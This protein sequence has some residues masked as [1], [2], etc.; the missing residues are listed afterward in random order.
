MHFFLVWTLVF[1]NLLTANLLQ[2]CGCLKELQI[3]LLFI[4]PVH[5]SLWKTLMCGPWLLTPNAFELAISSAY[6]VPS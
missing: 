2:V 1:S 5:A 4:N 6:E 3:F